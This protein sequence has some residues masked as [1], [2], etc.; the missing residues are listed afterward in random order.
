M[1]AIHIKQAQGRINIGNVI[2]LALTVFISAGIFLYFSGHYKTLPAKVAAIYDNKVIERFN[3]PPENEIKRI[4]KIIKD[5]SYK[6]E[7]GIAYAAYSDNV[8]KIYVEYKNFSEKY[9][10]S[11]L[12]KLSG[13][14]VNCYV[15]ASKI[16]NRS[17]AH[18]E[19]FVSAMLQLEIEE[20]HISI[21]RLNNIYNGWYYEDAMKTLWRIAATKEQAFQKMI[22]EAY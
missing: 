11:K 16:W 4:A 19:K 22:E 2:V 3:R 15:D 12:T 10:K 17:I 1:P 20:K 21:K 9:P 7:I 18:N 6:L 8:S 13:E 5:L 14:I